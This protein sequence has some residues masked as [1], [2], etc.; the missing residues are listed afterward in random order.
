[1]NLKTLK[2]LI[3]SRKRKFMNQKS[4]A[5]KSMSMNDKVIEKLKKT[6]RYDNGNIINNLIRIN[7]EIQSIIATIVK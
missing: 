1:M 3:Q 6:Y 2:R 7:N 5:I 4:H